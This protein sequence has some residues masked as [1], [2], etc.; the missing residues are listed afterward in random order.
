M[1]FQNTCEKAA[2]C[3]TRYSTLRHYSLNIKT[4]GHLCRSLTTEHPAVTLS[5][6]PLLL[7]VTSAPETEN[8]TLTL[9]R[10]S[11]S[12]LPQA[13]AALIRDLNLC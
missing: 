11:L 5:S 4:F 12:G 7:P 2:E 8:I 1:L 3:D 6:P 9:N 10:A 13:R